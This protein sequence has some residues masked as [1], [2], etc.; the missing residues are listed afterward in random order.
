MYTYILWLPQVRTDCC[1][2]N[3]AGVVIGLGVGN[4]TEQVDTFNSGQFH[5][6]VICTTVG[7]FLNCVKTFIVRAF[8]SRYSK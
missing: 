1:S 7:R 6:L 3:L 4:L 5:N 2:D 8:S